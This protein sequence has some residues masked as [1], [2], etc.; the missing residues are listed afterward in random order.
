MTNAIKVQ[1]SLQ[2]VPSYS[3]I[4]CADCIYTVVILN[5]CSRSRSC[6]CYNIFAAFMRTVNFCRCHYHFLGEK[7]GRGFYLLF[8]N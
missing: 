6:P 8:L 5:D 3:I 2:P 1:M 7:C 4:S